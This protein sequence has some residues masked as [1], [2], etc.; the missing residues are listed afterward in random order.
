[1]TTLTAVEQ[2]KI[3]IGLKYTDE[4]LIDDVDIEFFLEKE[5]NNVDRAARRTALAVLFTLSQYLHEKSGMELEIWGH[6]WF[7]NYKKSLE[8]F[9]K[10]P[11]YNVSLNM[12]KVFCGG[13]DVQDIQASMQDATTHKVAGQLGVPTDN[14]IQGQ[15]GVSISPFTSNLNPLLV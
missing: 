7:E 3:L 14:L 12:A 9:L 11:S 5:N 15:G 1:M 8:L 6:T 4:P 10:D 13:I 2:V